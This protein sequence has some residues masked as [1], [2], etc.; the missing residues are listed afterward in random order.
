MLSPLKQFYEYLTIGILFAFQVPI[1]IVPHEEREINPPSGTVQN[2]MKNFVMAFVLLASPLS[3]ANENCK[4]AIPYDIYPTNFISKTL[5]AKKYEVT[6][7]RNAALELYII[8][9]RVSGLR[10]QYQL[11]VSDRKN[12]GFKA[13]INTNYIALGDG[14]YDVLKKAVKDLPV[15]E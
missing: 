1:G 14:C 2:K 15:C 11:L 10:C 6:E 9:G 8:P 13:N 4:I 12:G 5:E 3:F 7:L